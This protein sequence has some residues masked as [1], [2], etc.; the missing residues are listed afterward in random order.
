M[1]PEI[2][3]KRPTIDMRIEKIPWGAVVLLAIAEERSDSPYR[4]IAP[5]TLHRDTYT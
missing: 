5:V 1:H 4:K 3:T 2:R